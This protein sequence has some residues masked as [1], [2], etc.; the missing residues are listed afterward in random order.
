MEDGGDGGWI[1]Q[2]DHRHPK[3]E[4]EKRGVC[5]PHSARSRAVLAGRFLI[6]GAQFFVCPPEGGL[7][8]SWLKRAIFRGCNM[9]GWKTAKGSKGRIENRSHHHIILILF[10][11]LFNTGARPR[12]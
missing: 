1:E 10:L 3:K 7:G 6:L 4:K 2:A 5:L 12:L 9:Q 11:I 8:S